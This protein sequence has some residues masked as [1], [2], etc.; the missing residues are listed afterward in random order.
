MQLATLL[1]KYRR[2]K[3]CSFIVAGDFLGG[4]SIAV[5]FEG[6]NVIDTL[7][8]LGVDYVVLGNHEFDCMFHGK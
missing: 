5:E 3:D 6:K 8:E 2:D 1:R 4:S 7:N